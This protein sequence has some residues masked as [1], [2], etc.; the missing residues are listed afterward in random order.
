MLDGSLGFAAGVMLAA[1]YWSLLAPA[2]EMASENSTYGE[3]FAFV[4]VAIGFFLGAVFVYGSDVFM[5]HAGIDSPVQILLN[6]PS[7][8]DQELKSSGSS[9]SP[10]R[11]FLLEI[12]R[13]R[14]E[15][16]PNTIAN[17][18]CSGILPGGFG[19]NLVPKSHSFQ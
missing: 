9:P 19:G 6:K 10:K 5:S 1:S 14:F 7:E 11:K 18:R 8:S 2:L 3:T 13:A 17:G 4:P 12:K 15:K 16:R